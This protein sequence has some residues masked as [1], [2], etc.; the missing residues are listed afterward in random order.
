MFIAVLILHFLPVLHKFIANAHTIRKPKRKTRTS[1]V[2][3]E[4]IH[5]LTNFT[6]IALFGF[7]NKTLVFGK[8]FFGVKRNAANTRKHFVVAICFPVRARNTR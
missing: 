2:K 6:V 7:G 3:H 1:F 8:F 5:F 4:Q